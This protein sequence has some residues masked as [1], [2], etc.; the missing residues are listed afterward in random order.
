MV[1]DKLMAAAKGLRDGVALMASLGGK[2]RQMVLETTKPEQRAADWRRSWRLMLLFS[3]WT[4][5]C[6]YHVEAR[7]QLLATLHRILPPLVAHKY[8]R[9]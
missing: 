4:A 6:V 2:L 7:A 8:I 5:F 1:L 9:L 3:G